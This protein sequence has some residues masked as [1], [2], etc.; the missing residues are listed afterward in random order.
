MS[1][2]L[3]F[4]FF[5]LIT[6]VTSGQ[7]TDWGTPES[8]C[9]S[10]EEKELYNLINNYRQQNNLPIVPLSRSLS[11]V[12]RV[13]V[14]DLAINRPDFG[15]CYLHSWSDKGKWKACCYAKDDN[16]AN[17][18]GQKP[19]ELTNYVFKAFEV[20]YSSDEQ[21]NAVEAFEL[22]KEIGLTNDYFLNTG[23]WKREWKA[24]GVGIYKNYACVWFGEGIDD[25]PPIIEC[26][27]D[28]AVS[29]QDTVVVKK[30]VPEPIASGQYHIII[31]SWSSIDKAEQ[32]VNT[33]KKNGYPNAKYI[34]NM[35]NYRISIVSLPD[36]ASANK[37][38]LK[39]KPKFPG[40]WILKP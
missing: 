21:A 10:S 15:G 18:M 2:K 22:W 3:L 12:A 36:E 1:R 33:L 37:A 6:S 40:A 4:F 8:H 16:R 39:Y 11:Y 31:G 23:K 19:K 30:E 27:A 20:V 9:I 17:C 26:S 35:P 38:L 13:H 5:I 29:I 24:V 14:M 28:T 32:E 34:L 7:Q 25:T